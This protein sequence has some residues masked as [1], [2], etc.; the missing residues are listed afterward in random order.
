MAFSIAEASRL[1][2]EARGLR[3]IVGHTQP[4]S[5]STRPGAP[6]SWGY[7]NGEEKPETEP[8]I[9]AHHIIRSHARAVTR[10]RGEL[11]AKQGE[12][13]GVTL[14]MDWRNPTS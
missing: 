14:D 10:Y 9:A 12:E 4:G 1:Q 2:L 8:Y 11:K 5:L 13:V 3:E 7:A 6:L